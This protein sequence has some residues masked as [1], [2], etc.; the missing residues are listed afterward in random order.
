MVGHGR[1]GAWSSFR[2][3]SHPSRF[4]SLDSSFVSYNGE[5]KTQ[6]V[7]FISSTIP[8]VG[9]IGDIVLN[10]EA[11][12]ASGANQLSTSNH[13]HWDSKSSWTEE[14]SLRLNSSL[15]YLEGAEVH[16]D[17]VSQMHYAHNAYVFST[18]N[19]DL[20]SA[21]SF[22]CHGNGGYGGTFMRWSG[23]SVYY[24]LIFLLQVADGR[25]V[26]TV[27]PPE[28]SR[29]SRG[30]SFFLSQGWW[31]RWGSALV[32][33]HPRQSVNESHV[34]QH[35]HPL[36]LTRWLGFGWNDPG[37]I[38]VSDFSDRLGFP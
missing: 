13:A 19:Y 20:Q 35:K 25:R 29:H 9:T 14:G 8:S 18:T 11:R 26:R 21:E 17:S 34:L 30:C 3:F 4:G 31:L 6:V 15:V 37:G 32:H 28:P 12:G 10:G 7:A 23:T 2:S 33:F 22:Y 1:N 38:A 5:M 36:G 24:C 16:W 27:A